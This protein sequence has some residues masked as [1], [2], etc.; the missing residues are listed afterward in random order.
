VKVVEAEAVEAGRAA[1]AGVVVMVV[2][3]VEAEAE[4]AVEAVEAEAVVEAGTAVIAEAEAVGTGAGNR[5]PTIRICNE[6]GEPAMAGSP[7]SF[8][9]LPGISLSSMLSLGYSYGNAICG[10]HPRRSL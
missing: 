1:V 4:V 3:A 8:S 5:H 2:E 6:T 9:G 7:V 10:K